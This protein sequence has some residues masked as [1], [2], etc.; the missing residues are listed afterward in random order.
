MSAIDSHEKKTTHSRGS[1]QVAADRPVVVAIGIKV[2]ELGDG[3]EVI[4]D[5]SA[6]N[7]SAIGV[8]ELVAGA[9][10]DQRLDPIALRLGLA[11]CPRKAW[12]R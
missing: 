7:I 5:P 12:G 6:G 1:H 10:V 11:E 9:D 8:S 4:V 3:G 2:G